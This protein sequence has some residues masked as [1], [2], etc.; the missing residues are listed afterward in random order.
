MKQNQLAGGISQDN[1]LEFRHAFLRRV[2]ALSR[3]DRRQTE[4]GAYRAFD[5]HVLAAMAMGEEELAAK[6]W[7]ETLDLLDDN[8]AYERA[9]PIR[10]KW[11]LADFALHP[12]L[13]AEIQFADGF[14]SSEWESRRARLREAV[15][16]F[17]W[18]DG[19]LSENHNM[20]HWAALCLVGERWPDLVLRG[21]ETAAD[22]FAAAREKVLAWLHRWVNVGTEEWGADIYY[23]VNLLSLLNLADL[24]KDDE[25]RDAASGTLDWMLT[26]QALDRFGGAMCGAARRSYSVYR[27]SLMESPSRPLHA[28]YWGDDPEDDG[29]FCPHFIG[30]VIV[31]AVS[32]YLPPPVVTAIAR[33]TSTHTHRATHRRGAFGEWSGRP[34]SAFVSR[35][36]WRS[37]HG[38]LSTLISP[39]G[40]DRYTEHVWQATLGE[41]ALVFSNHPFL[42]HGV[43]KAGGAEGILADY[44]V[45]RPGADRPHWVCGNMPPGQFG[46]IRPGYWQGNGHGPRSFGWENCTALVYRI[47]SDDPLPWV[48]LWFPTAAFDEV[49]E[50][51]R[52]LFAR[53]GLGALAIWTSEPTLRPEG[54][55]LW[56]AVER[57]IPAPVCG[58]YAQM[59][60]LETASE[61]DGWGK[62]QMKCDV[63]FRAATAELSIGDV[64]LSFEEGP[65]REGVP[66]DQEFA[67]YETPWG[68]LPHGSSAAEWT[69]GGVSGRIGSG[70]A[71]PSS[72]RP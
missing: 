27:Q 35:H 31:A 58:L 18:H 52:W 15:G 67:R 28:L 63:E 37:P 23:N 61:F 70:D 64:L 34:V 69:C 62:G 46:D 26:D 54:N 44:A 60:V 39:G 16:A 12:L 11:H 51:G 53:K 59:S 5:G 32:D 68:R 21:G 17:W 29:S 7:D 3:T 57:R 47:P 50:D 19:D 1:R 43:W 30:G 20:L 6:L 66:M 72:E 71:R 14:A 55:N 36:T 13:R 22:G 8:L 45:G 65:S 38:M 2:C 48:H 4:W 25:L 49:V 41:G 24:A 9:D 56:R 10:N 33:D 42:H 40:R